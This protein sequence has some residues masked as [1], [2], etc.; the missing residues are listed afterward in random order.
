[1]VPYGLAAAASLPLLKEQQM[2]KIMMIAAVAFL[3]SVT[4]SFGDAMFRFTIWPTHD[5][6]N[7]RWMQSQRDQDRQQQERQRLVWERD[8]R[9]RWQRDRWQ[10]EQ[11]MR[12][13]R[14]QRSYSYNVWVRRHPNDWNNRRRY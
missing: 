13:D 11:Q 5:Q 1:V 4:A 7:E 12:R 9:D 8:Q 10:N 14:H 3:V 2:K 6:R